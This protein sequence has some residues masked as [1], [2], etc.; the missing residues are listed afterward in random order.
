MLVQRRLI[1]KEVYESLLKQRDDLYK[2]LFEQYKNDPEQAKYEYSPNDPD[3]NRRWQY[4]SG[5][6]FHGADRLTIG[7][8]VKAASDFGRKHPKFGY[9]DCGC[10]NNMDVLLPQP[11]KNGDYVIEVYLSCDSD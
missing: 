11:D 6:A 9:K 3:E 5:L 4:C 7:R 2:A 8:E 1:A 10:C